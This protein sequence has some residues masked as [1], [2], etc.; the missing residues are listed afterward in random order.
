MTPA[1][2][3]PIAVVVPD[4]S[5]VK[6]LMRL[7]LNRSGLS[8]AELAR[9]LGVTP[10]C[11]GQYMSGRG[12]VRPS[13]SWFCNVVQTAGGRLLL[14]L[15]NPAALQQVAGLSNKVVT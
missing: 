4:D 1:S 3:S 13:L 7:L 14:E 11:V 9:R 8:Q 5:S 12:A 2:L 6:H 15:P 10:Q